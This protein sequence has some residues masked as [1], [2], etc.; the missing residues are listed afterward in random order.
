MYQNE[1]ADLTDLMV[2]GHLDPLMSAHTVV[3]EVLVT[4]LTLGVRQGVL[5][6]ALAHLQRMWMYNQCR[7]FAFLPTVEDLRTQP[8]IICHLTISL[9]KGFSRQNLN[10]SCP[11]QWG[12]FRS[13]SKSIIHFLHIFQGYILYVIPYKM[14]HFPAHNF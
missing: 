9:A 13:G 10:S 3:A 7:V 2:L 4:L 5:L 6:A 1:V 8:E 12:G 11:G 14:I